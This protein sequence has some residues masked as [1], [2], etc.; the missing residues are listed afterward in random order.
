MRPDPDPTPADSGEHRMHRDPNLLITLDD[1]GVEF[2]ADLRRPEADGAWPTLFSYIPYHKDGMFAAF[3]D[4]ANDYLVRHG[5][6]VI[7]VDIRGHGGS[8]GVPYETNHAAE[9][10][11]AVQLVEWISRQDWCDGNV[12]MW[13]V[14]YGA[15][16]SLGAATE[17][18]RALKAIVAIQGCTDPY[19]DAIWSHGARNFIGIAA[20]GA[21]MFSFRLMPP[22]HQDAG[23]RWQTVWRERL[24]HAAPEIIHWG[25]HPDFD[26]YWAPTVARAESI[27]V[28]TLLIGGWHDIFPE[29]VVRTYERVSG[30]RQLWMGPWLHGA[31]DSASVHP[32]EYLPRLVRWWDRWLKGVA[33]PSTVDAPVTLYVQGSGWREENE[34]P[35][36]R[37]ADRLLELDPAGVLCDRA[38]RAGWLRVEADAT[39]GVTAGLWEPLALGLGL[40]LDQREDETRSLSFTSARLESPIEVTGH[41]AASLSI[42]VLEGEEAVVAVKLADVDELGRSSLIT[43]GV[44]RATLRGASQDAH[45]PLDEPI[46]V[47]VPLVPT[48]YQVAAGHCLRVSLALAD[49][50]HF[51]PTRAKPVVEVLTGNSASVVRIPIVRDAPDARVPALEPADPAI[52][53]FPLALESKPVWT[54]ERDLGTGWVTVRT[55]RRNSFLTADRAGKVEMN[56]LVTAATHPHHP[57]GTRLTAATDVSVHLALGQHVEISTTVVLTHAT[58][59]L[60]GAVQMDGER[61]FHNTWQA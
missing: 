16:T 60:E 2:A 46:T 21:M 38:T 40:P 36:A 50:P 26:E 42:R 52:N 31:P 3:F 6:A 35:I 28:P 37:S 44:I 25:V 39:V 61:I 9:R 32:M 12:G 30:P 4:Y 27:D 22:L 29:A 23:E 54:T 5:Y 1:S 58:T 18:P 49:F 14:S 15:I 33:D 53:R 48:A 34:W 13:G 41:P 11:D 7:I 20:W 24:E 10:A 17:R 51:W 56:Q 57:E 59:V 47:E 8:G 43:S 19:R 45:V 55:G